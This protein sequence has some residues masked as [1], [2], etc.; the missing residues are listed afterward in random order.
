MSKV[1]DTTVCHMSFLP[2]LAVDWGSQWIYVSAGC[3]VLSLLITYTAI[4]ALW[5]SQRHFCVRFA[6]FLVL[7][8]TT[9]GEIAAFVVAVRD[10]P[11]NDLGLIVSVTIPTVMFWGAA[12][13]AI[14]LLLWILIFDLMTR[15]GIILFLGADLAVNVMKLC[16][17]LAYGSCAGGGLVG[18]AAIMT[19]TKIALLPRAN[20]EKS[21]KK[22]VD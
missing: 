3:H 9:I 17:A 20:I 11:V 10:Q 13:I 4:R 6:A 19:L 1:D 22:K 21:Q 7:L 16:I 18:L 15:R 8:G 14:V 5:T 2:T 12:A